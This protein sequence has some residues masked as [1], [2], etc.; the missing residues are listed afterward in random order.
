MHAAEHLEHIKADG[1]ALA[2]AARQRPDAPV[3]SCPG[4]DVTALVA[5][6]GRVHRWAG[7]LVATRSSGPMR[8]QT[9]PEAGGDAEIVVTWYEE[10][11]RRLVD[12]LSRIDPDEPVW[13][14]LA[15]G[16]GP[17]RFWHRRMAQETAIHRWDAEAAVG[18]AAPIDRLL[19]VDGID[20]Y[21]G[22]LPARLERNPVPGLAGSLHLH[23]TDGEGEWWLGLAPDHI[24][25]RREHAKADAALQGPASALFLWLVNRRPADGPELRAFGDGAILEAWQSVTF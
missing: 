4:W 11:L 23:A 7:D 17:A 22:M 5:H 25:Q 8:R 9:P 12:E 6:T 24:E 1:P 20:E 14:W 13:N 10:G 3:P 19:A 2:A 15:D 21:L 18:A 16:P